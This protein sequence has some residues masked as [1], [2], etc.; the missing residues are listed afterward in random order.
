MQVALEVSL[1]TILASGSGEGILHVE[2]SDKIHLG[3]DTPVLL[4]HRVSG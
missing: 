2:G 1:E 4:G 3:N